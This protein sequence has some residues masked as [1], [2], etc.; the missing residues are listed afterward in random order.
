MLLI[1]CTLLSSLHLVRPLVSEGVHLA[2]SGLGRHMGVMLHSCK[3]FSQWKQHRGAVPMKNAST[4]VEQNAPTAVSSSQ[5]NA[6]SLACKLVP[7]Q[8]E[9]ALYTSAKRRVSSETLL[10]FTSSDIRAAWFHSQAM[11]LFALSLFWVS[12]ISIFVKN[13]WSVLQTP[14]L[15]V[16]LSHPSSIS[17]L[18]IPHPADAD[19]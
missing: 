5:H 8:S 10:A 2:I 4:T 1:C 19:W 15:L 12:Q 6:C 17:S 7:S 16:Q 13:F 11:A 18:I 14:T 9:P 3:C